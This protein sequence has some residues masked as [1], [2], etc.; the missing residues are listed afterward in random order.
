MNQASLSPELSAVSLVVL[1]LFLASL[2]A[3]APLRKL[4]L[5][6]TVA[7]MLM[8]FVL[9]KL[10]ALGME[11]TGGHGLAHELSQILSGGGEIGPNLIFFVF[12]PALVFE[13]AHSLEARQVLKNL[14]PIAVLAVPVL[15]L[16]SVQ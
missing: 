9:G 14:L 16:T 7:V 8:G 15:L 1:I 5:P 10:V 4:R 13:S 6:F 11:N 2:L 12:L 3:L